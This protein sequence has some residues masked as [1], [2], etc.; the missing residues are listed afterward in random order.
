MSLVEIRVTQPRLSRRAQA[1]IALKAEQQQNTHLSHHLRYHPLPSSAAPT[2]PTAPAPPVPGGM[3]FLSEIES[4]IHHHHPKE[5]DAKNTGSSSAPSTAF[6][7]P[8][9]PAPP[10]PVPGTDIKS[11]EAHK[12]HMPSFLSEVESSL[13]RHHKEPEGEP[14]AVPTAPPLPASTAP[15]IPTGA[16]PLPASAPPPPSSQPIAVQSH[17]GTTS[18]PSH[19]PPPPS[20]PELSTDQ[21]PKNAQPT[22]QK[23]PERSD[24]L[25][26]KQIKG[27]LFSSG[28]STV[29]ASEIKA[30]SYV[31]S[32]TNGSVSTGRG[33]HV[34]EIDDSRFNFSINASQIPAPRKFQK[35]KHLYPGGTGSTVPLD[36]SQ[37]R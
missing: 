19:R 26:S 8:P 12:S 13:H 9:I 35:T 34:L 3:S 36:L 17:E 6:T 33:S 37:F 23:V 2:A 25:S 7:A 11:Q 10:P 4:K 16:P 1:T 5:S 20:T 29:P 32:V 18:L 15:P 30:D 21:A 27:R 28:S 31:L 24:T 14:G 22:I